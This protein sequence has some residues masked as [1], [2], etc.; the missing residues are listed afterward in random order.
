MLSNIERLYASPVSF[1][2]CIYC[3]FFYSPITNRPG[4]KEFRNIVYLRNER[5][6]SSTVPCKKLSCVLFPSSRA[7]DSVNTPF[8]KVESPLWVAART[9]P[10]IS[11]LLVDTQDRILPIYNLCKKLPSL[12]RT[13][14]LGN[15]YRHISVPWQRVLLQSRIR[16]LFSRQKGLLR[17]L[18]L[19]TSW[20]T[21][22]LS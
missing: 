21:Q 14:V 12:G 15:P 16:G 17:E 2:G 20:I 22:N 4:N 19:I 18:Y 8:H 6:L 1:M 11:S 13:T 7:S 5:P 3:R 9:N 10:R